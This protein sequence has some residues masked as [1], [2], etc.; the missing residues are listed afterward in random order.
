MICLRPGSPDTT[1]G[2][3]YDLYSENLKQAWADTDGR[4]PTRE[5]KIY[6]MARDAV[7]GG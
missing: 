7:I 6:Q 3:T 4:C 1:A 2:F 5:T